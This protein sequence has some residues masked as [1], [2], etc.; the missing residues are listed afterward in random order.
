M[1]ARLL[2]DA[3][4]ELGEGPAWEARER[5]LYWV[6]ILK[7]R[8]YAE[9]EVRLELPDLPGCLAPCRGGWL[10]VALHSSVVEID[11][12][13]GMSVRA[14]VS[15]PPGNRFNDGKCDPAGRLV[16][17]TMDM[18]EAEASGALYSLEGC[19]LRRMIS[20]VRISNGLAWSP[21][22][23]TFYYI[24][25]P[26][27]RIQA[28]D[29]S[30]ETGEIDRG[31]TLVQIP[32]AL[33]WPDGMTTDVDGNLWVAMWGGAQVLKLHPSRGRLLDSMPLPALQPTSCVFGGRSMN[34]LYI[35]SARKGM[36]AS[37]FSKYPL[38]GAV[39]MAETR[40]TGMP[41]FEFCG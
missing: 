24:D 16:V 4:A 3:R 10:I 39:F 30:L 1:Q 36:S 18:Q 40:V 12:Q 26:T 15:E 13:G 27:R 25:T 6:D 14:V 11:L 38:S 29:Y 34:E 35:T 8:I 41:T 17:G 23:K 28:F 9:G 19:T 31:R 33:G 7:K 21:D 20:G 5:R 37:Q 22:Y 2:F 32:R